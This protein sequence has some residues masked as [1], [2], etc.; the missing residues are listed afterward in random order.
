MRPSEWADKELVVTAGA[1]RGAR[2]TCTAAQRGIVDIFQTEPAVETV[3]LQAAAQVGKSS[4]ALVIVAYYLA[5]RPTECMVVTSTKD[6]AAYDFSRTRFEPL[7]RASPALAG[8]MHPPYTRELGAAAKV[9]LRT[10][11]NGGS[12]AIAG[13]NSA[14]SLAARTVE[15]LIQDEVD[16][17][18]DLVGDEG[19][20]IDVSRARTDQYASDRK[21]MMLST[22][23]TDA[24]PIA[25]WHGE[26][27]QRRWFVPCPEC[28]ELQ[29]LDWEHVDFGGNDGGGTTTAPVIVCTGCRHGITESERRAVL[30][31]GEW[32]ATSAAA[33]PTVAS[34]HL[35]RLDFP[36]SNLRDIV[37]AFRRSRRKQKRG[38][39]RAMDT[40][41]NLW[42]GRPIPARV[43]RVEVGDLVRRREAFDA[44]AP[45]AV[46]VIT[47]GADVQADRIESVVVG[48]GEG[49]E[50][51]LLARGIYYGD[52]A[53]SAA[54]WE[55]LD[56]SVVETYRQPDGTA[57][58]IRIACVD[59]RYLPSKVYAFV[60]PRQSRGVRAVVGV[61]GV[62][63]VL[64]APR[65]RRPDR[66]CALYQVGDD[67]AK[68]LILGRLKVESGPGA[69]H[70]PAVD[71]C[72]GDFLKG[73]ASEALETTMV[74]GRPV[75][76]WRVL[77]RRNEP[78]DCLK[79]ALAG[80][81][82]IG[83]IGPPAKPKPAGERFIKTRP[84]W[85]ATRF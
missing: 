19:H 9:L 67:E 84:G 23:T 37:A 14:P 73:I 25:V 1:R 75:Q 74:R 45:A 6:P 4:C 65:E 78:L 68:S 49:E 79:Y 39:P 72:S 46:Q 80:R 60:G 43:E 20:P 48:W 55:A 12:L 57:L 33:D 71:W 56:E 38:D 76:R 5:A 18:P 31:R 66:P 16:R 22:P 69:I 3:V 41:N 44:A 26:G 83:R 40:Y 11:K 62:R 63:P 82:M 61:G 64:G 81:R 8:I 10:A 34:F 32:R 17:W 70:L 27:D 36:D 50:S 77:F 7:V 54:P 21:I 2:W 58:G 13:A 85:K 51:W 42:L 28:G 15:C 47:L 35:S 30:E 53:S 52:T 59:S 29:P 24:A